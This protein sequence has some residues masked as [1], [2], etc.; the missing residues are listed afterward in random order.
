MNHRNPAI[1]LEFDQR[2][3]T[4]ADIRIMANSEREEA[5]LLRALEALMGPTLWERLRLSW[6]PRRKKLSDLA[7]NWGLR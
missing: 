5:F 4:V 3:G 2:N 6:W 1:L 7:T